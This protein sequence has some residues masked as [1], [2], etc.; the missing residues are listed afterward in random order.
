MI[1]CGPTA[2]FVLIMFLQAWSNEVPDG[3]EESL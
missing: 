1:V 3:I 2:L